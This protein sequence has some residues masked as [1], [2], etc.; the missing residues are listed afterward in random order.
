MPQD[1]GNRKRFHVPLASDLEAKGW[2]SI[3]TETAYG[4]KTLQIPTFSHLLTLPA[5]DRQVLVSRLLKESSIYAV[6]D[7]SDKEV[8][9]LAARLTQ[10][11]AYRLYEAIVVYGLFL[12]ML[13]KDNLQLALARWPVTTTVAELAP[14]FIG[15]GFAGRAG[16]ALMQKTKT[17]PLF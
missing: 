13:Y 12:N 16:L 15:A 4:G 9:S 11:L 6:L 5:K 14:F 3:T 17:L 8:A 7:R 1:T 10:P 2:V